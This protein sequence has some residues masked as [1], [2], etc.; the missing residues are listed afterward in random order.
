MQ[1]WPRHSSTANLI[2]LHD[3]DPELHVASLIVHARPEALEG[4][5]TWIL[6]TAGVEIHGE[7][8]EGKLVV[9]METEDPQNILDL[10]DAAQQQPDIFNAVLVYHEV[11][12]PDIDP[13]ASE[14]CKPIREAP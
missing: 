5:K 10:I 2:A 13:Q 7:S 6:R 12:R 3:I 4:V 11:L 8:E 9:V 1:S 14:A